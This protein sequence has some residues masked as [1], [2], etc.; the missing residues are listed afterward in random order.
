MSAFGLDLSDEFSTSE[1][2]F[3]FLAEFKVDARKLRDEGCCYPENDKGSW[4]RQFSDLV[5]GRNDSSSKK[6][7]R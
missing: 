3:K 6:E 2:F 1:R 5:C 7:V 4:I